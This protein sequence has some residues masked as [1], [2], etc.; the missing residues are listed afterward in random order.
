MATAVA[1]TNNLRLRLLVALDAGR[2]TAFVPFMSFSFARARVRLWRV[3]VL[4]EDRANVRT[5]AP[6]ELQRRS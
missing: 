3:F 6:G 5:G 4:V 1:T 2:V